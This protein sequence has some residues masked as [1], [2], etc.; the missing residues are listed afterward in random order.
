M[1]Q[2]ILILYITAVLRGS[3]FKQVILAKTLIFFL[4]KVILDNNVSQDQQNFQG[5]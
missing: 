4:I 1:L 2:D 3:S 5:S